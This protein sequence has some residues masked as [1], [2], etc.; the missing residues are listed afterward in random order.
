MMRLEKI[1]SESMVVLFKLFNRRW[2]WATLLVIAMVALF[3]RL[4]FWQLD[5]LAQRRAF[6]A[7]VAAQWQKTPFDIV[8][9]DVPA[10]LSGMEY[11]RVAATGNFDYSRQIVLK[12]QLRN[13]SPGVILITPLVFGKD[14]AVL[15]ARGWVP[16]N[17]SD[18]KFW[19]Q[20]EEPA[21]SPVIGLIQ[22]SQKLPS[23]QEPSIPATPQ[24]GWFYI[25]IKAIQPQMPYQLLPFFILQLPEPDRPYNKL[26]ARDDPITLD[27]GPHFG[28]AIQWYTFAVVL[29][30]GYLFFIHYDE[31]RRQQ[32]SD[33]ITV[34]ATAAAF[35]TK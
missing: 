31:K 27:E 13:D 19:P 8:K 2:W 16:Y 17:Q 3:I 4:G 29:G 7:R 35:P 33:D 10:D 26:P 21:G 1:S 22:K 25:N 5:R 34:P 24:T 20:F 11:R 28:Y 18:P 6:N 9:N 12:E 32:Q 23:G 30:I 15:V 14:R